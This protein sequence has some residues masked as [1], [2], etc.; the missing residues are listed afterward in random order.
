MGV[1]GDRRVSRDSRRL[2]LAAVL[3]EHLAGEFAQRDVEA[4]MRTMSSHPYLNHVPV[5]TGGYGRE[6]VE[7]FYRRHFIPKWPPDTS[8]QLISHTVGADQVVDELIVSFTHDREMDQLLPGVPPT[9]RHVRLPHVVVVAFEDGKVAHEHLYWDQ[10]SLLV[11]IGLLDPTGLPV[12]GGEQADR[13]SI[14]RCPP[15]P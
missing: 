13:S 14:P 1:A 9:G 6:E 15:T 8:V 3:D 4:T 5:M 10:A 11:Q 7:R 2:D 12:T